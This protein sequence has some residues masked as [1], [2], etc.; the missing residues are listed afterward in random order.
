MFFSILKNL[1]FKGKI[2]IID[3]NQKKHIFGSNEPFSKIR[4]KNKS[5]LD[6]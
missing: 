6:F 3:C 4:L 5:N 2:E 1:R